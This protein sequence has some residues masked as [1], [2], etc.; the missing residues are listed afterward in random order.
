MN[1]RSQKLSTG[2]RVSAGTRLLLVLLLLASCS[3]KPTAP[4]EPDAIITIGSQG[5]S[6]N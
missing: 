3:S 6:L 4:S 1:R 5:S 2:L